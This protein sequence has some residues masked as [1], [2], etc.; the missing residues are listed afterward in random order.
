VNAL[1]D[2]VRDNNKIIDESTQGEQKK[3]KEMMA[4]AVRNSQ[5][6]EI[7][8]IFDPPVLRQYN[9]QDLTFSNPSRNE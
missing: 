2:R 7:L 5:A 4:N 8:L 3:H 6:A 9:S 1:L